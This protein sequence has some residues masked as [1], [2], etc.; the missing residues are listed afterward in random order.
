MSNSGIKYVLLSFWSLKIVILQMYLCDCSSGVG[1]TA[2]TEQPSLHHASWPKSL[3]RGQHC[4]PASGLSDEYLYAVTGVVYEPLSGKFPHLMTLLPPVSSITSDLCPSRWMILWRKVLSWRPR[5]T[6]VK[7]VCMIVCGRRTLQR[8]W[9]IFRLSWSNERERLTSF[10]WLSDRCRLLPAAG[11]I[12]KD[13]Q[14]CFQ[15]DIGE[16]EKTREAMARELVSLS[17]D[18]EDLQIRVEDLTKVQKK[19]LVRWLNACTSSGSLRFGDA[20]VRNQL[21]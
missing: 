10:R 19:H 16:L 11:R 12:T 14:S 2:V 15:S 6:V 7:W 18:K 1:P 21:G 5:P 13:L 9:S 8:W 3:T 20:C 17:T 4:W